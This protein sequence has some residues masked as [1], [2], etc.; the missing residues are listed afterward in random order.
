MAMGNI[1]PAALESA[2][3]AGLR[4]VNAGERGI[5]R[6]RH[7]RGFVYVDANGKR[8]RDAATVARIRRLAIPPAWT[9]VWI[10]ST[11]RGHVQA[12]GRDAKG[13][14]QYRYHAEWRT[15]RDETKFDR[16]I[17]FGDV[18]PTIRSRVAADLAR[19]GLPREKVLATVVRLLDVTLI[20]VGNDEYARKNRSYGLTTL[21]D[22]HVDVRGARIRFHFRG[23][24]GKEHSVEVEDPKLA[25]IVRRCQHI[26]GHELFHYVDESGETHVV[27]SGDV[28][29]YLRAVARSDFTAKDFRTWA[30]T[31]LAASLLSRRGAIASG[32]QAKQQVVASI[33]EVAEKL[34]N[35][36][37]VCR[38]SYIHPVVIDRFLAPSARIRPRKAT[39]RR[40]LTRDECELLAMLQRH[41]RGAALR[42]SA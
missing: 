5:R 16:L 14:K 22:N 29:E 23:K 2:K 3:A 37:T 11:E 34:G 17:E 10:C 26:P 12:T 27:E 39:S 18:L 7:G 33:R 6:W 13:R 32:R 8:V 20:R 25:A 31:V 4:Y 28:N 21:R 1:A 42:A 24:A 15:T 38:K 35:T 36:P 40:G 9:D 19:T 41:A 30:G